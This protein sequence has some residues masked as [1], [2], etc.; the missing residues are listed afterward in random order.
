M[1]VPDRDFAGEHAA[2]EAAC[3]DRDADRA[4]ELLAA[5]LGHTAAA[6]ADIE[7]RQI[8]HTRTTKGA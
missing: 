1:A 5:H 2:L 7:Q 4:A 6:L 3:L 8:L